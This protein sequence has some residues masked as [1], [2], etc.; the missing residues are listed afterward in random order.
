VFWQ[1][2]DNRTL[3]AADFELGHRLAAAAIAGFA[4]DLVYL[5]WEAEGHPD[6]HALHRIVVEAL[7]RVAFAGQAFGYEVWNAMVPD[8]IV[9]I[10]AVAEQKRRAIEA[11]QS[12]L[13]YVDFAHT[14]LGLNAYR[15]MVHARGQGYCEALRRI[16]PEA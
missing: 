11:H 12:Q 8:V 9:D 4:P 14:I 5:P 1:K 13:A 16:T 2:P 15:S 7:A 6:H 10:T 3:S